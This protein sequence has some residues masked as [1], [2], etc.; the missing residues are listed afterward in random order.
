MYIAGPVSYYEYNIETKTYYFIGDEHNQEQLS[1]YDDISTFNENK[2]L[3]TK[4]TQHVDIGYWI[5]LLLNTVEELDIFIETRY[6]LTN[7]NK[8]PLY[9]KSNILKSAIYILDDYLSHKYTSNFIRAHYI[10]IRLLGYL[11]QSL[12]VNVGHHIFVMINHLEHSENKIIKTQ[13]IIDLIREVWGD[14]QLFYKELYYSL[15]GN[16]S[17]NIGIYD[18]TSLPIEMLNNMKL[19]IKDGKHKIRTQ[20][21]KLGDKT[22]NG[23][24]LVDSIISYILEKGC[25]LSFQINNSIKGASIN[26]YELLEISPYI[27][28]AGSLLMDAYTLSRL[29]RKFSDNDNTKVVLAGYNHIELYRDFLITLNLC[30]IISISPS[31]N[32]NGTLNNCLYIETRLKII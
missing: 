12:R 13:R 27:L 1:V 9:N 4:N 14:D 26:Y 29:F 23:Y 25:K 8:K 10:D 22:I 5:L 16:N 30:P 24:P 19:L 6:R 11:N 28:R 32:T 20:L 7:I 17:E 3:I 15:L 2:E 18:N 31:I 21:D